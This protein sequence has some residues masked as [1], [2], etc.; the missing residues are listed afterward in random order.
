MFTYLGQSNLIYPSNPDDK[1][2]VVETAGSES[3]RRSLEC[4][5][6]LAFDLE[7]FIQ[8]SNLCL[9]TTK[10]IAQ[11]FA[12]AYNPS[13]FGIDASTIENDQDYYLSSTGEFTDKSFNRQLVVRVQAVSENISTTAA[14]LSNKPPNNS[15]RSY[16]GLSV[17]DRSAVILA[18]DFK[19][20]QLQT[21]ILTNDQLLK[22]YGKQFGILSYGS[23]SFLAGMVLQKVYTTQKATA[24]F[25]KW[26]KI[27]P[28]W[29]P[30]RLKFREVLNIEQKRFETKTSFWL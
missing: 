11:E 10:K 13:L 14:N 6:M 19:E 7:T 18:K 24:L 28:R 5:D 3:I 8:K 23:C 29:V 25:Y 1:I 21:A 17:A 27:D 30:Q 22:S 12:Y 20:Q 26:K 16:K 2:L 4:G 9:F 15:T